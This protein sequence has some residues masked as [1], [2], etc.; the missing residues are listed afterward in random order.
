MPNQLEVQ[1]QALVLVALY[2]KEDLQLE[3]ESVMQH[4]LVVQQQALA[5]EMLNQME[6]QLLVLELQTL[7][8]LVAQLPELEF[9]MHNL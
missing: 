7:N 5:L 9:L 1:L 4:L 3:Q 2:H 6:V 8:Q